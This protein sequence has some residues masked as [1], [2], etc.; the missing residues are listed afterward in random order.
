MLTQVA[1]IYKDVLSCQCW[2]LESIRAIDVRLQVDRDVV[3]NRWLSDW[4]KEDSRQRCYYRK[5]ITIT[6]WEVKI[7]FQVGHKQE[8]LSSTKWLMK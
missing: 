7:A 3:L 2:E 6:R 5:N 4:S 1:L 8:K